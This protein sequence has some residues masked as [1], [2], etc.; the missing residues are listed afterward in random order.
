MVF[1]DA[2]GLIGLEGMAFVGVSRD[3]QRSAGGRASL[4]VAVNRIWHVLLLLFAS[5][6]L[7]F[8]LVG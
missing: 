7:V 6:L 5:N 2:I 1:C 8:A 3:A 4:C